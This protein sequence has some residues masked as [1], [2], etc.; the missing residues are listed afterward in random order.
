MTTN[1]VTSVHISMGCNGAGE[2]QEDKSAGKVSLQQSP[3]GN[4]PLCLK[5][6]HFLIFT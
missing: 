1:G 6:H 3:A 5:T 4:R 2:H